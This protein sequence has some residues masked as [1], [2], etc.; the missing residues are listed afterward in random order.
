[1][2]SPGSGSLFGRDADVTRVLSE[3]ARAGRCTVV[4]TGGVGKSAVARAVVD[5]VRASRSV[6]WVDAEPAVDAQALLG[7]LLR[8]LE[9]EQLPGESSA[10]AALAALDGS[11]NLVVLDGIERLTD[12]LAQSVARWPTSPSG[13]WLLMTSRRPVPTAT[14]PLVRLAPLALLDDDT[15]CPAAQM[16]IDE[17]NGRG[18]DITALLA[19]LDSFTS[20]LRS[21]GGIPVA[22]QLIADSVVR[23][24]AR[25]TAGRQMATEEIVRD[26]LQKTVEL[27]D[28]QD[29]T[30]FCRLGLTAGPFTQDVIAAAGGIAADQARRVA[31]RLVDHGL[32]HV[33]DA[34]FDMLPPIRDGALLLLDRAAGTADALEALLNWML[35]S[36]HLGQPRHLHLARLAGGSGP[37]HERHCRP[38]DP[39]PVRPDVCTPAPTRTLEPPGVA[40]VRRRAGTTSPRNGCTAGRSVRRRV[41][42]HRIRPAVAPPGGGHRPTAR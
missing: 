8:L 28:D 20:V 42:H 1:M 18:G 19:D 31:G 27:L 9:C 16:L 17:A 12:D 39:G 2:P 35:Q 23:F 40:A 37:R 33:A 34:R 14:R 22:I 3:L 4:G 24:G 32:L 7:E 30:I 38:G 13:P 6:V 25:L 26:C 15:D 11:S 21:T 10:E 5:Q 36:T 41:R 29:R